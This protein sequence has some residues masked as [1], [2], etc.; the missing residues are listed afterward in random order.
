MKKL[1]SNQTVASV[2]GQLTLDRITAI[3]DVGL[4]DGLIATYHMVGGIAGCLLEGGPDAAK[5]AEVNI[6]MT[7]VTGMVADA[8]HLIDEIADR[9]KKQAAAIAAV[10]AINASEKEMA[11]HRASITFLMRGKLGAKSPDLKKFGITPFSTGGRKAK[12][13]AA[14]KASLPKA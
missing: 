1:A 10:A 13:K 6:T 4:R 8:L 14:A 12:A 5:L 2:L 7:D 11:E 3:S 9:D